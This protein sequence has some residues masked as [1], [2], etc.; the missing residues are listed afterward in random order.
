MKTAKESNTRGRCPWRSSRPPPGHWPLP[1]RNLKPPAPLV[2]HRPLRIRRMRVH[3]LSCPGNAFIYL[4]LLT[5]LWDPWKACD[6][7]WMFF[8]IRDR[9]LSSPLVFW[10]RWLWARVQGLLQFECDQQWDSPHLPLSQ[11][12]ALELWQCLALQTPIMFL[13][14]KRLFEL[15]KKAYSLFSYKTIYIIAFILHVWRLPRRKALLFGQMSPQN[16][17]LYV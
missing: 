10:S 15:F 2:L 12:L 5:V 11:W 14:S 4:N 8:L 7:K 17:F 16:C 6:V 3:G 9:Q 1:L 13:C